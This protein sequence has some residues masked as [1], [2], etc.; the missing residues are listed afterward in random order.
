MDRRKTAAMPVNEYYE[1]YWTEDGYNPAGSATPSVRKLYET[2]IGATDRCLD[3]GCGDGSSAGVWIRKHARSYVGADIATTALAKASQR[4]LEVV[5]IEDASNL[6][7]RDAEFDVVICSE[8]LEHLFAPHLAAAE[9]FRV[10]SPSGRLIVT[11]P[12]A[13]FWRERFDMVIGQWKPRGDDSGT[14]KPWRSPHIRFFSTKS[15]RRMLEE[16][17][18]VSVAVGGHTDVSFCS[19]IPLL[20]KVTRPRGPTQLYEQLI[21]FWPS[22]FAPHLHALAARP[23]V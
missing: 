5:Q 3:V 15:L 13:M 14:T 9:M 18:F 16:A 21:R 7:F 23:P 1:K 11:V 22:I 6:P 10:L 2:H 4:G 8:V 17:G 20:R 12:N 19:H